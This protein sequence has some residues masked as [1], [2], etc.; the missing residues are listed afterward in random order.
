MADNALR[1]AFILSATD[2]M[3]RVI[4][5]AVK[6]STDKLSAFERNA[7][8]VGRGMVKGG[9]L[10][11]GAGAAVGGAV[12]SAGKSIADYAGSVKDA[13]DSTGVNTEAW[14][15]MTYAAKIS[16]IEQEKLMTSMVKFD[17]VLTDAAGGSKTAGQIFKDLGISI[18]DASG[19]MRAPEAVFEDVAEL[20]AN[21]EDGATKTAAACAFFGKSGAELLPMLNEGR[22]G[23]QGLYRTAE[24]TGNVLANETLTAADE[25]GKSLDAVKLQAQGVMLQLGSALIPVLSE[26]KDWVSDVVGGIADWLKANPE[27]ARTIGKVATSAAGILLALGA[28]STVIGGVAFVIGKFVSA[29]RGLKTALDL[30]RKA[31]SFFNKTLLTSPI[32][33]IIVG[34]VAL[35]FVVYKLIKNWDKVSAFFKRLWDGIKKTFG[36]VWEWIKNMFLNYTP[37]GLVIKHWDSIKGWFSGLWEGVKNVFRATWDWIKKMFLNYTPQ[38][39]VIKHWDS[40]KGWFSGLWE[41]V[42]NVFRATWDWIKKMF[43]NYTPQGLVIKHWDSIKGWFSGLWDGVKGVFVGAWDGIKGFFAELNPVE[44]LSDMWNGIS[45]FFSGLW[46]RFH[47]GGR[48]IIQGLIDGITGMA[49]KAIDGIKNIGRKIANGFKSFFGIHSPS[50]LFAEYGA[51]ITAGLTVGIDGGTGKVERSTSRMAERANRGFSRNIDEG[52]SRIG[53]VNRALA[54]EN[55]AAT[56]PVSQI[57]NTV[58]GTSIT[59]APQITIEAGAAGTVEPDLRKLLKE[60]ERDILEMIDR[61]AANRARLSF[62]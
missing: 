28:V 60:H 1:L 29:W 9:A 21:V 36:A 31:V 26:M 56:V 54:S 46:Q 47:Q 23:L 13:S 62:A 24:E 16:G 2:K 53:Q 30:G 43:L 39:L 41:G 34:V 6:K 44:W 61:A 35:A 55:R 51:N 3:S 22:N 37:Q 11:M 15:K 8:K 7:S 59:Y 14:Q 42:K 49:T 38:G 58:G 12:F 18:K 4:D 52:G 45:E 32:F 5:A 48:Q 50:K 19:K 10:I 25:F 40:I 20:L 57:A 17:K 33:W 27:L